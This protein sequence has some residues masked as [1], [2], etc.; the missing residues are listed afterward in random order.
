MEEIKVNKH[1]SKKE[2][3]KRNDNLVE[4]YLFVRDN[5]GKNDYARLS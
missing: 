5:I 1:I 4:Y 2:F 3:L